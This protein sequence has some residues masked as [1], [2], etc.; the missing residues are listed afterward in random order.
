MD[1]LEESRHIRTDPYLGVE[2]GETE[3]VT[4]YLIRGVLRV[5]RNISDNGNLDITHAG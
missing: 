1:A 2:R 3:S 5:G 4:T